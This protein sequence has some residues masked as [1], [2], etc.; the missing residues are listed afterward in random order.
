[1]RPRATISRTLHGKSVS[2]IC[3]T[4]AILRAKSPRESAITSAPSNVT[5]PDVG[6]IRPRAPDS[7]VDLPAPSA[8]DG[9]ELA[10]AEGEVAPAQHRALSVTATTAAPGRRSKEHP[11]AVSDEQNRKNGPPMAPVITP[12]GS[13]V[14]ARRVRAPAS[15]HQRYRARDETRG[16]RRPVRCAHERAERVRHDESDEADDASESD[17]SGREQ[18][19]HRRTNPAVRP[20]PPQGSPRSPHEMRTHRDVARWR[21]R[22]R[23]RWRR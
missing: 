4:T 8:D 16:M 13:S 2:M 3:G 5:R 12:T 20:H 15:A 1:M 10:F 17:G 22:R 18:R 23:H 21:P 11:A 9:D 19:G 7:K 6:R 14:G